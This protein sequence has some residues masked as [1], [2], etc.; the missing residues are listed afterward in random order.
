[1]KT[2]LI[3]EC[4]ALRGVF[5]FL[6]TFY[7]WTELEYEDLS[8]YMEQDIGINGLVIT[9]KTPWNEVVGPFVIEYLG[10]DY[11]RVTEVGDYS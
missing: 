10:L 6:K 5:R 11:M 7:K 3:E 4:S 1:M 9:V 2:F 8:I